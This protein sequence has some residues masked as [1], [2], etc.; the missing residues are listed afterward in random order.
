MNK[1]LLRIW[2]QKTSADRATY[3]DIMNVFAL[4]PLYTRKKISYFS[5]GQYM[6]I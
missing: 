1:E 5:S 3:V 6:N 4:L 2:L